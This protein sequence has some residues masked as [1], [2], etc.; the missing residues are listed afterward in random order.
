LKKFELLP[1]DVIRTQLKALKGIGDWTVD[2]YLLHA[3]RRTDIFPV[4]DLALVNSV[5]M[6]KQLSSATRDELLE[7]SKKWKPYRSIA[8]MLF[9]HYYIKKKNKDFAL[10]ASTSQ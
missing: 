8:T 6:V 5:K 2:I 7:L 1:D 9:W 3:L 10:G 4:G